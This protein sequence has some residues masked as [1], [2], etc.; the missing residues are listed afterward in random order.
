MEAFVLSVRARCGLE[1][2]AEKSA[3]YSRDGV[4]PP[5]TTPGIPLAGA[6]VNGQWENG[7][8]CYGVPIGSGAYV[9]HQLSLKVREVARK[10][11]RAR[12][13][14]ASERQT[15]WT[16]LRQSFQ[17][18]LDWWLTLVYPSLMVEAAREMDNI[19]W[20]A[21][22][23]VASSSI[24]RGDQGLGW[25]CPLLAPVDPW[26][27]MSYQEMKVRLP[28]R[29]GG[30]GLASMENLSPA[31]FL[32]GVQQ[33]LPHFLSR[34]LCPQVRHLLGGPSGALQPGPSMWEPLLRSGCQTGRKC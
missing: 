8:V 5:S 1:L 3:V 23:T 15:L 27:G 21:L 34:N 30:L 14:L 10:T 2:V 11:L 33:A 22:E 4:L 13:V 19:I 18:Q 16:I 20:A 31:A 7:L 9:R 17:Q 6:L 26:Q 25:D 24:P 29:S 28:A 12:Q 32:G